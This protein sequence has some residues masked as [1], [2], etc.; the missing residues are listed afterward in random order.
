MFG[1]EKAIPPLLVFVLCINVREENVTMVTMNV[2]MPMETRQIDVKT[3]H[4]EIKWWS[5][6]SINRFKLA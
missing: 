2:F 1:P 3:R 5:G 4:S 6:L